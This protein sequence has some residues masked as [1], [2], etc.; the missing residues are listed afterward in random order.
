MELSPER[1]LTAA[2]P[3]G[4]IDYLCNDGRSG[5]PGL[6]QN[7]S[8]AG[9]RKLRLF[10][11]ACVRRVWPWVPEGSCRE[12]VE[13]AERLADGEAVAGR[14]ADLSEEPSRTGPLSRRHAA[15]AATACLHKTIRYAAT[16]AAQ[17]AARAV[18]F[19]REEARGAA[20][21]RYPGGGRGASRL[22]DCPISP[23][24]ALFRSGF[25][26]R[27]RAYGTVTKPR[28]GRRPDRLVTA[29]SVCGA[30]RR[31]VA[32]RADGIATGRCLTPR[33]EAVT[34]AHGRA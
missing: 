16:F 7:R 9:R 15:N 4:G 14:V 22:S 13:L 21:L 32:R 23:E 12:A 8:K 26:R 1:W 29:R 18:A 31:V 11:C 19:A 2:S 10:A 20:D 33:A 27:N 25:A 17:A 34:L 5:D 6:A 30:S 28:S 3:H 24:N